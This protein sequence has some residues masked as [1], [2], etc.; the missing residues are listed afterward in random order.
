M[1][2]AD[3]GRWIFWLIKRQIISL[4][5]WLV[6][7]CTTFY[8][9][10]PPLETSHIYSTEEKCIKPTVKVRRELTPEHTG[11]LL[12]LEKSLLSQ[13]LDLLAACEKS[14]QEVSTTTQGATTTTALIDTTTTPGEIALKYNVPWLSVGQTSSVGVGYSGFTKLHKNVTEISY[15]LF[16]YKDVTDYRV[17]MHVV[18]CR[19]NKSYFWNDLRTNIF[20]CLH[21]HFFYRYCIPYL[22]KS[23]W[24]SSQN[25]G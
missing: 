23:L 18:I 13:L 6:W 16:W 2:Q 1:D 15:P 8:F 19:V 25:L 7:G 22:S 11:N 3:L 21:S 17:I 10:N 12:S 24:K 5:I 4:W 14:K 20:L 9:T